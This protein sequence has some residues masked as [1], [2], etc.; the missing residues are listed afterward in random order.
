MEVLK[1]SSEPESSDTADSQSLPTDVDGDMESAELEG[2]KIS[3][4]VEDI[5]EDEDSC[6]TT[7][8]SKY[9]DLEAPRKFRSGLF[10]GRPGFRYYGCCVECAH[11]I[12]PSGLL[13]LMFEV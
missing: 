13:Q 9:P 3:A 4:D 7:S 12:L 1:L 5:S 2:M 8:E 10:T 11:L 6:S